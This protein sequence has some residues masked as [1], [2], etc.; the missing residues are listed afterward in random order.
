MT[1][2]V[3][4]LAMSSDRL[5]PRAQSRELFEPTLLESTLAQKTQTF[6]NVSELLYATQPPFSP[7]SFF[8][9]SEAERQS[10]KGI[11]VTQS[12]SLYVFFSLVEP[13][14][15]LPT[16]KFMCSSLAMYSRVFR[17]S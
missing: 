3:H 13:V 17:G 8:H 9:M 5:L 1:R 4:S 14:L 11:I 7:F 6:D 2:T 16:H 15:G 12:L 10:N